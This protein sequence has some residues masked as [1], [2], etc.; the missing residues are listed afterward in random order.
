MIRV[1]CIV[2]LSLMCIGCVSPNRYAITMTEP[3]LKIDKQTGRTWMFCSG[4]FVEVKEVEFTTV[5]LRVEKDKGKQ[6]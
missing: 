3:I 4:F 2:L 6:L 5:E 1:V